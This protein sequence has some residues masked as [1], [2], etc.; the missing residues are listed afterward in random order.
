MARVTCYAIVAS[1]YWS[2]PKQPHEIRIRDRTL[3]NFSPAHIAF[4]SGSTIRDIVQGKRVDS[5][6]SLR[7][8]LH[9]LQLQVEHAFEF[10][11]FLLKSAT[12]TAAVAMLSPNSA[13]FG[14]IFVLLLFAADS[15][16]K[17]PAF[18]YGCYPAGTVTVTD[19]TTVYATD[20]RYSESP[21]TTGIEA[22]CQ[23]SDE[24]TCFSFGPT[25]GHS[26]TTQSQLSSAKA[27]SIPDLVKSSDP[28]YP[29]YVSKVSSF[30]VIS[31]CGFRPSTLSLA[32]SIL[33]VCIRSRKLHY[34][35]YLTAKVFA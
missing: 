11:H 21:E 2:Q 4:P 26:Q 15:F 23:N 27:S 32:S 13:L 30:C 9:I 18:Q 19:T 24:T 28:S 1:M 8:G 12:R 3:M 5:Q 34:I 17:G 33:S 35:S 20:T 14:K 6:R 29:P 16:A 22:W 10:V 7:R 25:D 31:M